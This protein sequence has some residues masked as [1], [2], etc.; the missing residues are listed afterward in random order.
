MEGLLIE[1]NPILFKVYRVDLGAS[2]IMVLKH[3]PRNALI[4]GGTGSVG[5][6]LV[7]AFTENNYRVTFQYRHDKL[8]AKQLEKKFGAESIQLNFEEDFILPTV[9]FDVVVNNAGINISDV[10]AH[11]VSIQDWDRTLRVN[12]TAPFH[13]VRQCLPSMIQKRWG[14]IIN[15]S[16]IYGLRAVEGNFPYTVSKHGLSGFTKTIAKEYAAY[17]ITCNE[18]C[19][20]PI[21]SEMI[22]EIGKRAISQSGGTLK[23]YLKEICNEIPAKR[24]VKPIEL[25]GLTLFLASPEAGYLTGASI[26][27]D[28]GM[29]A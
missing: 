8:T 17:G 16:S 9:D 13:I 24:M 21:D 14:R 28:G 22:R 3:K 5:K 7:E 15:I 25:A 2:L 19:P 29:I 4:T 10:S 12:L 20:G 6:A 11:E 23:N 27:M 26:P 18:I 1:L